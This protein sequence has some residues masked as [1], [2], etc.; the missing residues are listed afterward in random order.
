[1]KYSKAIVKKICEELATGKNS[2]ADTCK[3]VGISEAIFYRWKKDK[4]EFLEALKEVEQQR[5]EVFKD[6]AKSGLAKLLDM[7]TYEEVVT[8]YISDK[9]G[10]PKI[11]NQK[12]TTKFIMPSATAVL[13]TLTNREPNDWKHKEHVDHTTAGKGFFDFLKETSSDSTETEDE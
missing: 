5:L 8:E 13:F 3:K 7:H 11:K 1:M 6:M 2:V 10:K 12:K 9:E 4:I